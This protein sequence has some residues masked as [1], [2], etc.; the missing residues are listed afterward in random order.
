MRTF[1]FAV[2]K[3]SIHLP[4]KETYLYQYIFALRRR[5]ENNK[6]EKNSPI[7][8]CENNKQEKN[9]KYFPEMYLS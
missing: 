6:Q 1:I 3:D 5:G 2:T 9:Y 7:S 8:E 4:L